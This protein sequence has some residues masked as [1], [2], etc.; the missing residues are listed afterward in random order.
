VKELRNEILLRLVKVILASILASI[1]Y[2]VAVGPASV[3][4]SFELALLCF[5][6]AAAA[7]LLM[8]SSPI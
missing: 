3:A 1:L 2:L 8:E 7:I 4:G 6:A 5:A